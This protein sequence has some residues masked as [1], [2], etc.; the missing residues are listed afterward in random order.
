[1]WLWL[2]LG[3]GDLQKVGNELL[4]AS[5]TGLGLPCPGKPSTQLSSRMRML[6][7][8]PVKPPPPKQA[9]QLFRC[10]VTMGSTNRW[11]RF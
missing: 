3:P 11:L 1:M 6:S 5:V 8:L 9:V 7:L 4:K 10:T 2:S